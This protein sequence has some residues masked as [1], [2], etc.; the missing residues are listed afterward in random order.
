MEWISAIQNLPYSRRPL[1]SSPMKP[2]TRHIQTAFCVGGSVHGAFQI[3]GKIG[4]EKL[5]QF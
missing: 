2:P 5:R 1:T 4:D 3:S